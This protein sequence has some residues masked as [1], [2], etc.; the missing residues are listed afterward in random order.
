M[1]MSLGNPRILVVGDIIL[2]RYVWG[3]ADRISQ[4]APVLILQEDRIEH[5]LG[6]A[7]SVA[8]LADSIGGDVVIAGVVGDDDD[9]NAL[10]AEIG[11]DINADAIVTDSDRKTTVKTRIMAHAEG[12]FPH[13]IVRIDR[14]DRHEIDHGIASRMLE[15]AFLQGPFDVVLIS[16]YA[17]GVCTLKMI[18]ELI[19]AAGDRPIIVDPSS[20]GWS[21]YHGVTG[22]T[23]NRNEAKL[24]SGSW[25]MSQWIAETRDSEGIRLYDC[26]TQTHEDLPAVAREVCDVTGAGDTV[27][28]ML[29]VAIGSGID[30]VDA[31]RLANVAAGLQV[32]RMGVSKV[33]WSEIDEVRR[34]SNG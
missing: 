32:Q 29:G 33:T 7:A 9:A 28:A 14:E 15:T 31:C 34:R 2:D 24:W 23:P 25:S 12:R 10:F 17:K 30:V 18:E 26:E 16:D 3:A 20:H 1:N 8:M 27:L 22:I 11:S 13:Q 6:G 21:K 4:E 19:D 5:R